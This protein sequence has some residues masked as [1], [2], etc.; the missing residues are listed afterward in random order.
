MPLAELISDLDMLNTILIIISITPDNF[1]KMNAH[2]QMSP[3]QSCL[4]ELIESAKYSNF[5]DMILTAIEQVE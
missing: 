2:I 1:R 5:I 4:L 3:N